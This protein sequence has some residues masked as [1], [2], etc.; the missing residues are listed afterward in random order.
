MVSL[1]CFNKFILVQSVITFIKQFH[2]WFFEKC[3][4][5]DDVNFYII[6][7]HCVHSNMFIS[8]IKVQKQKFTL[9]FITTLIKYFKN[10]NVNITE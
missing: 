7:A 2:M 3:Y 1:Q 5:L 10:K 4:Q 9:D 8:K 6:C